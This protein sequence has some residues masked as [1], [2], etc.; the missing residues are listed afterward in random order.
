MG[1]LLLSL[2]LG[3]V[4]FALLAWQ[5]GFIDTDSP[6]A[7][8]VKGPDGKKVEPPKNLGAPLF[9]PAEIKV[10]EA[11][12]PYRKVDPIVVLG[13]MA[14]MDKLDVPAQIPGQLL[15]IGEDIP[16]GAT[17]VAGLA[18]FM[19]EPFDFT[20]VNQGLRDVP[21]FYRRLYESQ[22]VYENQ[23]VAMIDIAKSLGDLDM[24]R[25]KVIAAD[26]D[27]RGAKA[28]AEEAEEKLRVQIM[29]LNKGAGSQ[30]EYRS[31][32]LTKEKMW[33]D[34]L[35]K[36]EAM[37]LAEIEEHLSKIIYRQH[38][39]RNKIPVRRSFIQKIYK[40]RGD[41][42]KESEAVMS[43]S[44]L[45]RLMAE[46]QIEVEYRNRLKD[47]MLVTIEPTIVDSP[48]KTFRGHVAAVNCLVVTKDPKTPLIVSGGEDRT[49]MIWNRYLPAYIREFKHP[50]PVR[51]LAVSPKGAAHNLLLTGC[52]DGTLRLYDLDNKET[53]L[54]KEVREHNV[55]ITALDFSPDGKYFASG[56]ADGAIMLWTTEK[57][58][59]YY[60]FDE[61]HGVTN[62]HHGA[63]SWLRFTPQ[64]RLVSSGL[65]NAIRV[66][67]LK[68]KGA[69]LEYDPLLG[70]SG[71]V[72]HLDVTAD[73]RW[74]LFD[75]GKNLQIRSVKDGRMINTLQNPGGVIPFETV[76]LFSPDA[77]LLLTAGAG[78]GRLQLWRA[79]TE[80]NRGFEIRQ[81]AAGERTPVSCA[82]FAPLAD[83][84]GEGT[85]AV[86]ANKD[87]QIYLWPMPSRAEVENHPIRN[88]RVRLITASLNP[89]TRQI[90]IGVE[91]PNPPTLEHPKGR[92][93]PG[94]PV[95]IVIE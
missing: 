72:G 86:S 79:P 66:W 82:A 85:F 56:A 21:K 65:D 70:R 75:Q 7:P 24:K 53:P 94:R 74:L 26:M 54:V 47:G 5:L 63:I 41:A 9:E 23:I 55:G 43:L 19:A 6:E 80:A 18:A 27:K 40:Q 13:H 89:S 50:E 62:P 90:S 14:V 37:K 31:A 59:P 22:V 33:W 8:V 83:Y 25:G 76:A 93:E 81:L 73:G 29:L 87:G 52:S 36:V 64:A 32:K 61:A 3:G 68:E 35:M 57:V 60:R 48:P 69:A 17:Q 46:A 58:T 39:I 16:E 78:E 45:D 1:R 34:S 15:F 51:A 77:S 20:P 49:V 38:E 92:L 28:I 10:V 71:S 11:P 2:I 67:A 30:E 4:I 88:V 84:E 91:V 44:S 95:T 42:V 12:V